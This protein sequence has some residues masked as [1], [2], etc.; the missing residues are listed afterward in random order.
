MTATERRQAEPRLSSD[1][2]ELSPVW[3]AVPVILLQLSGKHR[4]GVPK[5]LR[6][7]H[8]RHLVHTVAHPGGEGTP[9][10]HRQ[11]QL[12]VSGVLAASARHPFQWSATKPGRSSHPQGD[13][14]AFFS[15][16]AEGRTLP[17]V[18]IVCWW[19][20]DNVL[21][22]QNEFTSLCQ[23][24]IIGYYFSTYRSVTWNIKD[25]SNFRIQINLNT[26]NYKP[27]SHHVAKH[28]Q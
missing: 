27:L 15:G 13:F 11:P 12:Q 5:Q 7:H 10:H 9:F 6:P 21:V 4:S 19:T 25:S 23:S 24:S 28:R 14:G 3:S 17:R 26:W 1:C 2:G 22:F 8:Q 20:A 16:S 18:S